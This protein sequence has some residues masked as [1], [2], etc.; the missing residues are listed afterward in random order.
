M[1]IVDVFAPFLVELYNCFLS[2]S[3][4]PAAFKAAYITPLLKK[5]AWTW[6]MKVLPSDFQSF[7]SLELLDRLVA[8]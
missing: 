7:G 6:L 1:N 5:L 3:T 4:V 2:T 8:P